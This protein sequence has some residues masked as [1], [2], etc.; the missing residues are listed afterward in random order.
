MGTSVVRYTVR[1]RSSYVVGFCWPTRETPYGIEGMIRVGPLPLVAELG[2]AA[3]LW[4]HLGESTFA[5]T[6]EHVESAQAV[7]DKISGSVVEPRR[8]TY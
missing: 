1:L 6:W 2:E 5:Y 7:S 4:A 3:N 8:V